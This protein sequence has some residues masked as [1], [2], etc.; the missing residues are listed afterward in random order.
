[1]IPVNVCNIYNEKLCQ[2][3][4]IRFRSVRILK[5]VCELHDCN[6]ENTL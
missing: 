3:N 2:F 6:I 1:M 4:K 5:Y